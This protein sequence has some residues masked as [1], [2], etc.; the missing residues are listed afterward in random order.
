MGKHKQSV[1]TQVLSRIE[2]H[3]AGWVFT[4]TDFVDLGSRTAVAT[5]LKRHKA[6]GTIRQLG[7]GIY[8]I[9][10]HHAKLGVLWPSPEAIVAS[11]KN[12]D[13]VRVKPTGAYAANLLGLSDQVPS[14]IFYLTDGPARTVKMGNMT[15]S[16]KR[17]TP[18]NMATSDRVS[19]LVIQALRWLGPKNVNNRMVNIL[20]KRF[21]QSAKKQL[22]DD[23]R[24]SPVWIADIMRQI[25]Q[26]PGV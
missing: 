21:D 26:K 17:T 18:R 8:D 19:G 10:R 5:A 3:D 9:P 23:I 15:I 25:A 12:R 16:F 13:S 11:V 7:R 2:K 1:D 6:C 22:L 4:P 20:R 24:Y 14:K